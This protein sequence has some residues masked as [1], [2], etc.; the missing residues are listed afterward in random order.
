MS[1]PV[2]LSKSQTS[3]L[4][5][6]RQYAGVEDLAIDPVAT[7]AV[8]DAHY[9]TLDSTITVLTVLKKIFPDVKLFAEESRKRSKESIAKRNTQVPSAKAKAKAVGWDDVQ[10]WRESHWEELSEQEQLLLALYTMRPPARA[11]YTPMKI[12][13]RKP[14]A[15]EAG[16]NYLVWVKKPYFI[17]HAYK[18]HKTYG[19][20][21]FVLPANLKAVVGAWLEKRPTWD[22]LLQ[23]EAGVAWSENRLSKGVQDI[24]KRHHDLETGIGALRHAYL[25]DYYHNLPSILTMQKVAREMMHSVTVSHQYIHLNDNVITHS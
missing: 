23:D 9:K 18:T 22:Y 16:F 20:L 3:T 15:L 7:M 2:V 25:T 11:D 8:L 17:F 13:R 5:K 24:F 14:I 21:T 6:M 1:A 12:V 19:D 10:I 4:K